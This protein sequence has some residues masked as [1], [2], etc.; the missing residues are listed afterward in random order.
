VPKLIEAFQDAEDRQDVRI[1]GGSNLA[2]GSDSE[3]GSSL[4]WTKLRD[5]AEEVVRE[6][7]LESR[8]PSR[9]IE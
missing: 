9:E 1:W 5:I 2:A 3:F 8:E 6:A 4:P 7:Y